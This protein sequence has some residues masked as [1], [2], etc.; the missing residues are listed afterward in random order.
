MNFVYI[1][2]F[3]IKDNM[4]MKSFLIFI[5]KNQCSNLFF[6][7]V[8]RKELLLYTSTLNTKCT[9]SELLFIDILRLID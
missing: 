5:S 2:V 1:F 6:D 4:N 9:S 3:F 8:I 7:L